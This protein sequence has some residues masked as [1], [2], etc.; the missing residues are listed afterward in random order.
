MLPQ[1][2]IDTRDECNLSASD[3][4]IAPSLPILPVLGENE[5][6]MQLITGEME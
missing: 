5:M 3:N 1:K 6:K 4:L 2:E